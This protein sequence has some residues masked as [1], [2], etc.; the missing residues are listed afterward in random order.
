MKIRV[1]ALYGCG[2]C[3]K[4]KKQFD[5]WRVKYD[6]AYC[7]ND[8][9]NCDCVESVVETKNYPIV[10]LEKNGEMLEIVYLTDSGQTL[11]EGKKKVSGILT[12]PNHSV[13]GIAL[14]VKNRLNS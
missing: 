9:S 7:E 4:I 5:D 2:R 6:I 10:I 11:M 12:V 14:Y 8:P 3:E 13:D 1:L